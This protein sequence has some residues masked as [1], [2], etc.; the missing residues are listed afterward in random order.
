MMLIVCSS[1]E[2]IS[3]LALSDFLVN[4]LTL[5]YPYLHRSNEWRNFLWLVATATNPDKHIPN[6]QATQTPKYSIG[7]INVQKNTHL[8]AARAHMNG[9]HTRSRAVLRAD[10]VVEFRG[11]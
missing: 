1:L 11:S 2:S 7:A 4:H 3:S 6:M 10:M 5:M 9:A 8:V